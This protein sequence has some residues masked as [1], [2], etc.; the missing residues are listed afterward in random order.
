[1]GRTVWCPFEDEIIGSGGGSTDIFEIVA[2]SSNQ[3]RLLAW[4]LE[5]DAVAADSIPMRLLRRQSAGTGGSAGVPV[6]GNPNSSGITSSC[7]FNVTTTQGTAS[8]IFAAF[9]WE[10]LGPEAEIYTPEMDVISDVSGVISLELVT[11]PASSKVSGYV[12]W[13]E[14]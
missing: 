3:V 11:A 12:C 9:R 4:R 7:N 2:T 13:E 6:K 8:D 10:Q 14:F 5:S 1:M